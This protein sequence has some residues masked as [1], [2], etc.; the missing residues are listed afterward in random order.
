MDLFRKIITKNNLL[1]LILFFLFINLLYLDFYIYKNQAAK[2][3][4][5]NIYQNITP[6]NPIVSVTPNL[7]PTPTVSQQIY[8]L[9]IQSSTPKE[10]YVPFGS[11]SINSPEWQDVPGL[12]A[13]IDSTAYGNISK[14]VFEASVHIPTGNETASVRLVNATDGRVIAGSEL[15]FNGNASSTLLSSGFITLDYAN[16]L[17]KIQMKTQL[18]YQAILDQ[19]RVHI[20]GK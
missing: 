7:T 10:Y 8:N 2:T 9:P 1:F 3:E 13:Y 16:K 15:T 14:V 11:G 12:Q 6:K 20:T 4:V 17:Y 18:N 19:A 5:K